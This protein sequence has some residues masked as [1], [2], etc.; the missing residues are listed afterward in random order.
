VGHAGGGARRGRD[1]AVMLR[2]VLAVVALVAGCGR[3]SLPPGP[4]PEYERPPLPAWDGGSAGEPAAPLDELAPHEPS[5]TLAPPSEPPGAAD[6]GAAGGAG[7][8]DAGGA[9]KTR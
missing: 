9:P 5:E 3:P 7:M 1:L 2:W 6:G 4:P 8:Q